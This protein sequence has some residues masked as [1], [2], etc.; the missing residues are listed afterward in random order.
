M[1]LPTLEKGR[2]R[3]ARGL[4]LSL[5]EAHMVSAPRGQET[6]Q[7]AGTTY[8]AW[9]R[10]QGNIPKGENNVGMDRAGPT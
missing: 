7:K 5:G 1:G 10:A 8:K 9:V 2:G 4:L 6:E 3:L